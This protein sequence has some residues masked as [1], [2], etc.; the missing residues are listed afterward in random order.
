MSAT[1]NV[2][3]VD[4]YEVL[5]VSRDASDQELKTAYRKLAMQYHPDRNPGDAAAEEK[6]KECSEAYQVLSDADKRAAYDRY[7]HAAFNG[8]SS[9]NG[10]GPFGGGGFGNAQDLGDIFGDLFGEMFNMGGSG[11]GGHASRVQRG[12]DLRYDLTLEFEEAAFGVE[13]E[14]KIRRSEVCP[15]C[16]GNGAARGKQPVTCTQCG[17][18]GQQRFQQGFFSV[19]RTCSVCGGTGT[20]IV[21]PC[22]TCVGE[23]RV[24]T[25]H[26]ILVKVPAGVEQDTRIRY[27][28]EGEAGKF[29]GPSGDLYVVLNVKAHKFFERDGDDLH[30]VMPISYPQAALGTDLEIQTLEG[31]ETLKIPE[32]VQSGREFKL[33]GKGVPH[34]NERGKGDLIVEIRVQ[35]PTKLNRH[36]KDLLR[37]LG[38]T[39]QV[40]NTPTS[41][42]ILDKVKEMFN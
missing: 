20:L 7:G 38:E 40:E 9:G 10:G 21:D 15:D 36:Q 35:T 19:A 41:R 3:K 11:R 14:I 17:G 6:F 28:G 37:E 12:R 16:H 29:G 13:R 25:E 2:T 34:L 27:Q 8:S 39:M 24:Q 22:A 5:S 33:R 1:A 42:G 26:K 18:R 4:F 31:V 30:C 32:G 23:T